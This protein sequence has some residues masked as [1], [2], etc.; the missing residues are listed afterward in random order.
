MGDTNERKR[1]SKEWKKGRKG[2][3]GR[4]ENEEGKESIKALRKHWK[5]ERTSV[6]ER[7]KVK[8]KGKWRREC[9]KDISKERM[10][11]MKDTRIWYIR[12]K[13]MKIGKKRKKL[14]KK[15]YKKRKNIWVVNWMRRRIKK[16]K[17][18]ERDQ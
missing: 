18:N 17:R 5:T 7:K 13:I 4:K 15:G 3:R 11:A 9:W 10:K 16:S 2:K 1:I 6:R 14:K 12:N 8:K